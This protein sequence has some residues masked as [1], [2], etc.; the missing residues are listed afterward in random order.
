MGKIVGIFFVL[1]GVA[2]VLHSW[3]IQQKE[4][5]MRLE[6]MVRF[7][8]KSVFAIERE[9]IKIVEYFARYG[10]RDGRMLDKNERILEKTLH[11]I[12]KRLATNT[13][14]MGH[15]AWEEVFKEEEQNWALDK[16]T[17]EVVLQAGKGFFGRSRAEN[18]CFL[19]KSIQELEKRQE[20]IKEKDV[21][22]RKVW[23]PVGML[24]T[25]MI[26]IL[27]I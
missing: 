14:P 27:F 2:G 7:L 23:V 10:D 8:Q 21:Q 24:G 13:Y 5:Q 3:M 11:E 22:E 20:K 19:Q 9:K 25:V 16:E 6:E 12:A 17:F 26:M 15:S 4:R 18:I 1:G